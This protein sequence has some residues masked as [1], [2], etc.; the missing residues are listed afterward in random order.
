MEVMDL[1]MIATLVVSFVLVKLLADWCDRSFD[2]Q[3]SVPVCKNQFTE[4]EALSRISKTSEKRLKSAYFHA[5]GIV[6]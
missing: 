4:K 3:G 5:Y 6:L 1:A 2:F